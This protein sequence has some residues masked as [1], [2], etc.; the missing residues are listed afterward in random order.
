MELKVIV[1][2]QPWAWLIVNGH[3]NI[4][5]RTWATRY[6]GSLL[7]QASATLPSRAALTEFR[8][9]ASRRGVTLPDHFETGGIVG[10]VHVDDCV[11]ESRSK[12]FDGPV[13]WALSKPRKLEF[14]K[15]KGRLGI[16]EPPPRVRKRVLKQLDRGR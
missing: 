9:Y 2:R 8:S 5:N 13:G 12:W 16:F 1:V 11:T 7:I 3:K 4:E 6:R 15:M 10:L 14:L